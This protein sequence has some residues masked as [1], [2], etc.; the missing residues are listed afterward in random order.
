MSK[1]GMIRTDSKWSRI[2][3][4]EDSLLGKKV[5]VIGGTNGI[6]RAI[7]LEFV[8]KGADVLVVGR[9]FRDQE[10]ARLTFIQADLSEMDKVALFAKELPA[11]F[12]DI[13]IMTHGIFPAKERKTNS[14]E[15]EIDMATSALSHFAI[16]REIVNRIGKKRLNQKIKPRVFVWGFPGGKRKID[17]NDFNS[18]KKIQ[19]V[20]CT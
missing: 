8:A 15:I 12:L 3:L 1:F 9:T 11:E 13:L 18:E 5:A 6:G 14:K 16:L 7:A 2:E 17:L 10:K 4:K 19:V 20:S